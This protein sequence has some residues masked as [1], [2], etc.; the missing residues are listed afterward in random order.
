MCHKTNSKGVI[1]VKQHLFGTFIQKVSGGS[2]NL[3]RA[4][5]I[6]LFLIIYLLLVFA[7]SVSREVHKSFIFGGRHK[8]TTTNLSD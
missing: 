2:L 4:L 6:L 8:W 1:E 3:S 5:W 7:G